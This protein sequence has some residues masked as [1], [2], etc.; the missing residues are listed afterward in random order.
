MSVNDKVHI[1]SVFF[2]IISGLKNIS[3]S[4]T[5]FEPGEPPGFEPRPLEQKAIALPLAPPPRLQFSVV[6]S[7]REAFGVSHQ[8]IHEKIHALIWWQ[9][10]EPLPSRKILI[11]S[12]CQYWPNLNTNSFVKNFCE[13]EL[14]WMEKYFVDLSWPVVIGIVKD[15]NFDKE[16]CNLR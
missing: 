13:L 1:K 7:T 16:R 6:L 11:A 4:R 9:G 2:K 15:E 5:R 10:I 12:S 14:F 8:W 3:H